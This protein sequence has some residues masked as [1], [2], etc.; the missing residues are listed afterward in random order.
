MC[1]TF[2]AG[3]RFCNYEYCVRGIVVIQINGCIPRRELGAVPVVQ[4]KPECGGEELIIGGMD[5]TLNITL[6]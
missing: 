2:L 5:N 3:I 4:Y 6:K 1:Y